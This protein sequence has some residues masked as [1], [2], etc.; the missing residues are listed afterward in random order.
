MQR[1]S[2]VEQREPNTIKNFQ[3]DKGEQSPF[4]LAVYSC[5]KLSNPHILLLTRFK[6]GEPLN[7]SQLK[8]LNKGLWKC[9]YEVEN[10][11]TEAQIIK[12][13]IEEVQS[14]IEYWEQVEKSNPFA[15]FERYSK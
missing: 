7:L 11:P 4:F 14:E 12:D 10:K 13:Q 9:Y 2:L 1:Q 5:M 3:L 6:K 15:S 8:F